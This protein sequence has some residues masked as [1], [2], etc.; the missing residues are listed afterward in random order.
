DDSDGHA[1]LDRHRLARD[2][3]RRDARRRHRHR[4]LCLERVEQSLDHQCHHRDR[5]DRPGRY[6]AGSDSRARHAAGH[7]SGVRCA[8]VLRD[9]RSMLASPRLRGEADTRSVAGEGDSPRTVLLEGAPHPDL[10]PASGEKGRC[11]LA[12]MGGEKEHTGHVEHFGMT[13]NKFISIEGIA[14]RYPGAGGAATTVFENLWLSMA[15]REFV[16]VIGH[17][18]CGKPPVLNILAGLDEPSEGAVLVDG[19]MTQGTSL[20]RAVIFQSHALLPW[21]TVLGNVAF[22]VTSK[23]RDWDRAKVKAHAQQF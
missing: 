3:R 10:L 4:L 12:D 22:A 1:D 11:V 8:D 20:D 7:V 14:K 5:P 16:C 2:R 15:R 17:S 21:R 6:A 9:S 18:G 13:S 23:W 19:Q